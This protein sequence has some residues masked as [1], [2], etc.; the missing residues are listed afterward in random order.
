MNLVE[1]YASQSGHWYKLD[2]T[3]AYTI[4]GK[5]GKERNTTLRDARTENLV[6]SV[7]TILKVAAS[8]GLEVWKQ[9]QLLMAAL[10][11]PRVD[12]EDEAEYIK[13]IIMDSKETASKAAE[14]GT[15]IH[16]AIEQHYE[17]GLHDI[18]Y[19]D[20]VAGTVEA[21]AK[22]FGEQAWKA[23]KSFATESYGGKIDLHSD[24]VVLDFKTKDFDADNFPAAYDEN[25][26]QLAA[27]RDGLRLSKARCANVFVSRTVPGLV[28][29]VEHSEESLQRAFKMFT[30]LLWYWQI[31]NN[32]GL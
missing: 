17:T 23:E 24:N 32:F 10:T 6:P 5:N 26:M 16:G 11:L 18:E 13:R 14:R 8:P 20:F 29:V 27:Y 31:K 25:L 19:G 12:G 30:H 3:P 2:G 28:H 1:S 15:Q 4:I 7:T 21:V 22:S 9:N